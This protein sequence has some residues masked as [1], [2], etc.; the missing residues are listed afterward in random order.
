MSHTAHYWAVPAVLAAASVVHLSRVHAPA[1]FSGSLVGF[2][3]LAGVIL[4]ME[5]ATVDG[6][7]PSYARV[8]WML[9]AL[10][11]LAALAAFSTTANAEISHTH[12]AILC[13]LASALLAVDLLRQPSRTPDVVALHVLAVG[14][15]VGLAAD[16]LLLWGI[17]PT[18]TALILL[19]LLYVLTG[20]LQ[21]QLR[22]RVSWWVRVEYFAL[23]ALGT[24]ALLRW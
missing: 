5:Y 22:E 11:Y 4:W 1:A 15:V 7:E 20:T 3:A 16:R 14:V 23:L 6:D 2:G 24:W 12:A 17:Q 10:V 21:H 9:S 8:R 19:L 18:R 13:G